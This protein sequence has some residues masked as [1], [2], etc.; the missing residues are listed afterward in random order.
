MI[1]NISRRL[2]QLALGEFLVRRNPLHYPRLR[3][4]FRQL[5]A[6]GVGERRTQLEVLERSALRIAAATTYGRSAGA[7]SAVED[8]PLLE[9][10]TVRMRPRDFTGRRAW[11]IPSSTGGTTGIPLPLWRSPRSVA[12]EQAALDTVMDALG[13]DLARARVAVL[14]GDDVKPPD[15]REP[16][17]WRPSHGG[18][19]LV[20]SS[21]HLNRATVAD[22]A[23]A[24]REFRAD[25]WWVYPTA[26]ESLAR[27]TADAGIPLAV[28]LVL[29]SSEVLGT[30]VREA[31]RSRFGA[32]VIDHYG[33]AERVAF[34]YASDDRQY[35]FL[36]GYSGVEL[37]PTE[38]DGETLHEIV[39]TSLWNEAMPLVRY[40]T[41]DL[42]RLEGRPSAAE[43]EEITLGLRAFGGILGR[44]GDI[45]I[46]P[47]GTRLTGIDHFHRGVENI[48]RIQV[49]QPARERV[50]IL[51]IPAAGFGEREREQVLANVRKKLPASI[52]VE[53]R[54]VDEL[55]R[56]ALGKTPFV[57]REGSAARAD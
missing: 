6:S 30:R 44:D 45:L 32:R 48:V 8:W 21:N 53:L 51:L 37:I 3:A 41:G 34:A 27:L 24:L 46:A 42:I 40:R 2:K 33:Q 5:L 31:A 13:V 49:L 11:S 57:I 28:P 54:V 26:V 1:R 50:E 15:D 35:R 12:A 52:A 38:R 56:T 19:R 22:Y 43:L 55:R 18:R 4:L 10:A 7:R 39:G 9:P 14:R 16:P 47:D 25:V 20:F 17:F 36:P 23:R 29:S